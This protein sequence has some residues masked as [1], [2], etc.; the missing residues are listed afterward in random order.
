MLF[1]ID[2]P[3]EIKREDN[4]NI[5]ILTILQ[6]PHETHQS[7]CLSETSTHKSFEAQ[8]T[9]YAGDIHRVDVKMTKLSHRLTSRIFHVS[10]SS[11]H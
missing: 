10:P 2:F 6:F 7:A 5:N 3:T 11:S 1:Q 8:A 4:C 9:N